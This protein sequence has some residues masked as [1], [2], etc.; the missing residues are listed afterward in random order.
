[1]YGTWGYVF[2]CIFADHTLST[3]FIHNV[4]VMTRSTETLNIKQNIKMVLLNSM[5]GIKTK[6]G[7]DINF[8][9]TALNNVMVHIKHT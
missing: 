7:P 1:M 3:P 5:K 8:T 4:S 2:S 6:Q 9:F